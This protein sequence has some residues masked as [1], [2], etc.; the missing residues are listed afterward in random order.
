MWERAQP[1]L[2]KQRMEDLVDRIRHLTEIDASKFADRIAECQ[3]ELADLEKST[4]KDN[5][6]LEKCYT[7]F[8]A[9]DPS[10]QDFNELMGS[11]DG[12]NFAVNLK[13]GTLSKDQFYELIRAASFCTITPSSVM[14][15]GLEMRKDE[16]E[17][18]AWEYDFELPPRNSVEFE[19]WAILQSMFSKSQN[20]ALN[21]FRFHKAKPEF[22]AENPYTPQANA[23]RAARAPPAHVEPVMYPYISKSVEQVSRVQ[24]FSD[25]EVERVLGHDMKKLTGLRQKLGQLQKLIPETDMRAKLRDRSVAN[26]QKEISEHETS[27]LDKMNAVLSN[28]TIASPQQLRILQHCNFLH[29]DIGTNSQWR[30]WLC[31]LPQL[32]L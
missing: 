5:S 24:D 21:Y 28:T 29:S 4:P 2:K 19:E 8:L 3:N 17:Q 11:F 23:D 30:Y 16:I 18:L 27:M 15:D 1:I 7:S 22:W 13:R 14:P 10:D 20:I 9:M 25:V 6:A 32:L 12:R 26:L 31:S